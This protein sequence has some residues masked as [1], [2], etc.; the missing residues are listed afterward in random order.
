M[1]LNYDYGRHHQ[2]VG[3]Y[4]TILFWKAFLGV[5]VLYFT[6]AVLTKLSL[7]LLY[8]RLFGVVKNFRIALWV[9]ALLVTGYWIACTILAFLRLSTLCEELG[10]DGARRMRQSDQ[11]L[12]RNG[13]CNLLIDFLILCLPL[14]MV[15][16]L[17]ITTRQK[18]MLSGIFLLGIL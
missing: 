18:L 15:W 1:L 7:L 2:Y 16:N 14:P 13:I 12:P 10:Q 6:N 5:Q 9:S 8:R 4:N 3:P 11:F 17:S